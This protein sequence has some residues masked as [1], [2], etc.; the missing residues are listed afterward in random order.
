VQAETGQPFARHMD[1]LTVL[2]VDAVS[3]I[4]SSDHSGDTSGPT[5]D[6]RQIE[7]AIHLIQRH[8]GTVVKE[9]GDSLMAEFSDPACAVRAGIE[10]ERAAQQSNLT[11][12]RE[13]HLGLRIG[14]HARAGSCR[15]IDVFSDLVN[16]AAGI[17]KRAAAGQILISRSVYE[18][19]SRES[20]LRCQWLAKAAIHGRTDEEDIFEVSW[21]EAPPNVPARYEILSQIGT[22]GMGMVYKVQDLESN[23]IIALKV[24]KPGI[25]SDPA[26]Q[27]NLRREVC[28][29]R[30]VTH[31]NV[32]RIHEFNRSNGT[33]C[34]SMEFIEGES[35]S[36]RLRR[37]GPFRPHEALEFARQICA[38]LREAHAQGIVHR[39]LKPANILVDRS[40]GVKIMDFGIARLV[41]DNSQMTGAIAGTPAYMAPEQVELKHVDA[42]TD[43]Y[44]LGLLLYEMITGCPAFFGDN[45]IAVAV[46]QIRDFPK[47]PREIMPALAARTEAIILKCLQKDP[48]KRFQSVDE[49]D[50]ALKEKAETKPF[51]SAWVSILPEI[52]RAGLEAQ[53]ALCRGIA[54]ARP[55]LF[56][57]ALKL[58]REGL[59]LQRIARGWAQNTRA[60]LRQRDWKAITTTRSQQA[61]AGLGLV[62]V[63]G[64]A[65][66]FALGRSG[67]SHSNGSVL[68]QPSATDTL[69]SS[70]LRSLPSRGVNIVADQPSTVGQSLAAGGTS[71]IAALEVDLN[72]GSD[73]QS[74]KTLLSAP[75]M[76]KQAS[77]RPSARINA[78]HGRA[79]RSQSMGAHEPQPEVA[80]STSNP[81]TSDETNN[82]QTANVELD[83]SAAAPPLS[84][85][86]LK[87]AGAT[88]E[89]KP[90]DGRSGLP[91][92]YLE[93]GSFRDATWA[94]SAVEKLSQLGFHAIS[95]HKGH[96]WVQSYHVQVG[97]YA[98]PKDTEDAQH[99]LALHGFK[100]HL[101]K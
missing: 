41:N 28:L 88:D 36:S 38:G 6:D 59:D 23:E 31:K 74:E 43:I 69:Q 16:W 34:I 9:I 44:A 19:V 75:M 66:A 51:A 47:R 26:M 22:G 3:A 37:V 87:A 99:A 11:F 32:C 97:P 61:L 67:K 65:I 58:R 24:L 53:Q 56:W 100:S 4:A 71:V 101:A 14:I 95:V 92:C 73:L 21:E 72:R 52:Q 96:L 63:L 17:T 46:K 48:A 90:V 68:A 45:P 80:P 70:Q 94:D 83:A 85:S 81:A 76:N 10:I 25:A 29:A 93:V 79:S 60:F 62:L 40:G 64:S 77:T 39:D 30:K 86:T 18:T 98:G 2:I 20:D 50:L 89:L 78:I 42:R 55:A 91:L 84:D 57:W 8:H 13:K 1:T 35:L 49:L 33:A 82:L 12:P 7:Q 5:K 15:G 27:E 54:K